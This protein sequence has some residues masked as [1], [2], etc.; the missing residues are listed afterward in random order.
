MSLGTELRKAR[1]DAGWTQEQLAFAAGLDRAYVSQLEHDH[2][3]PTIT[4]L[5]LLCDALG[6][7]ASVVLERFESSRPPIAQSGSNTASLTSTDD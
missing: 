3:S 4:V 1:L 5:Y 6:I 7:A 2:K